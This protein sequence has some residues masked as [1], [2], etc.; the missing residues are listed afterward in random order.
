MAIFKITYSEKYRRATL[1]N[2]GCNF[3]CRGCTYKLKQNPRPKQFLAIEA[4][5]NCL[6]G[7]DV[8]A[9]HFMGG[10]PTT[11]PQL[12]ELLAFCKRELGVTTRLGHTNGSGLVLE[13]LDGSNVSFKAFDDPVAPR[14]HRPPCG[15]FVRELPAVVCGRSGNEGEH[16]LQSRLGRL[17]AGRESRGV[18]RRTGSEHPVSRLGLHPRAGCPLASSHGRRNGRSR[19][20]CPALSR[21]R[22]VLPFHC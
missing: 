15:P 22:V 3:R 5:H 19:G 1:H 21:C 7:L 13:H 18:C 10:E 14:V 4:I 2:W 16:R 6:R 9:V 17:G 8:D 20:D 12:P 11:N